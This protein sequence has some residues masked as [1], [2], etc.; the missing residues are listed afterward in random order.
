MSRPKRPS[1]ENI[2]R[3]DFK[4]IDPDSINEDLFCSICH[5]V[6]DTVKRIRRCKHEFCYVC[7]VQA[8]AQNKS[9]PI[10]RANCTEN[11]LQSSIK[12]QSNLELLSV[13]C[14]FSP[15]CNWKGTRQ[16]LKFHLRVSDN[17][18]IIKK[19]KQSNFI[20]K[21]KIFFFFIG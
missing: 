19:K 17:I 5:D 2:T 1:V 12:V 7:I 8:L 21:K 15:D 4:Y 10:C 9:C 20:K 13:Y 14:N 18:N 16:D 3:E 11:D 6:F